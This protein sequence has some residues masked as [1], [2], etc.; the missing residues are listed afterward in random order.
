MDDPVGEG[1]VRRLA[2]GQHPG[3]KERWDDLDDTM[4]IVRRSYPYSLRTS[5][6][7][8][9]IAA[10]RDRSNGRPFGDWPLS[11]FEGLSLES[12]IILTPKMLVCALAER[13]PSASY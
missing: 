8:P 10:S 13:N 12:A 11:V 4:S 7:A 3:E 9:R 5:R 6:V 1:L 2:A